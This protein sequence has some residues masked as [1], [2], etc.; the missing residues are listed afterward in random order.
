VFRDHHPVEA[1]ENTQ[2]LVTVTLDQARHQRTIAN[3]ASWTSWFR[4][5]QVGK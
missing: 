5:C 4:L 2:D 1:G 3:R